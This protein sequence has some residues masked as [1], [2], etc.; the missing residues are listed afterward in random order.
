MTT[1]SSAIADSRAEGW[2]SFGQNC[3]TGTDRQYFGDII[4]LSST[5]VT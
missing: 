4:G 5:T 3:K 1:S 2:L